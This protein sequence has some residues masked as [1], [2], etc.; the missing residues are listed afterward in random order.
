MM[1]KIAIGKLGTCVK[2]ENLCT[3]DLA[4]LQH[5]HKA[6]KEGV[7]GYWEDRHL[8]E[9]VG[10]VDWSD[11]V[12]TSHGQHLEATQLPFLCRGVTALSI[13]VSLISLLLFLLPC[14]TLALTVAL[15][16]VGSGIV[17]PASKPGPNGGPGQPGRDQLMLLGAGERCPEDLGT[18]T[19]V[20]ASSTC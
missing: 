11:G 2:I 13:T 20:L 8:R 3:Q 18:L 5:F 14:L 7:P 12:V 9:V 15:F 16:P 19:T 17:S 4:H 6:R 1:L 10:D